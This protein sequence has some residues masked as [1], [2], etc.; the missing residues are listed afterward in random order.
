MATFKKRGYK[1]S[2]KTRNNQKFDNDSQTAEVFEKLDID[3]IDPLDENFNPDFHQAMAAKEH[4]GPENMV[5]E[6][7][8][9][10]YKL[11]S[12]LLRPALVIV[13]KKTEKT[14]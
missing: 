9:K 10:G 8:Q 14:P 5:L 3:E 12:K 4:N 1:K 11:K 2:L 6:V 7:M 13:S